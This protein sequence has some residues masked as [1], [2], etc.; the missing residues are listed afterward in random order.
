MS[1]DLLIVCATRFEMASFLS[2]FPGETRS[3]GPHGLSTISG[4]VGSK[5]Y[6]LLI[7]GPG[8]FNT[9][10]ALTAYLEIRFSH[11][12]KDSKPAQPKPNLSKP[13]LI[14]QTGI[15]GVFKESGLK[16]GDV[17]VA[18]REHYLHTGVESTSVV[19]TP[20]PFPLIE[21]RPK[22]AQGIYPFNDSLVDDVYQCLTSTKGAEALDIG[23]GPFVTVSTITSSFESA[24][25][26][27]KAF[28]SVMEAMEGAACAHVAALYG[29]PMVEFRTGSNFTGERDKDKWDMDLAVN[30]LG[31]ALGS[32]DGLTSV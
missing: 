7:T 12:G 30:G 32:L 19:N 5:T 21:N 15:A 11:A 4:G 25:R 24:G 16:V 14:I 27:S 8:V 10:H 23:K 13:N 18:T 29:I 20:L 22:S 9:I 3:L 28:G 2:A 6:E 1:P 26:I 17:A 31:W